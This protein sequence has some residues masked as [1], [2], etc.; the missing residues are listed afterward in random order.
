MTEQELLRQQS[1]LT[2]FLCFALHLSNFFVCCSTLEIQVYHFAELQSG[3]LHSSH[4]IV[5]AKTVSTDVAT[6]GEGPKA[7]PISVLLLR[8]ITRGND[9]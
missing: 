3:T 8:L 6:L 1:Q 2:L 9:N 4:Q 5:Y 7:H